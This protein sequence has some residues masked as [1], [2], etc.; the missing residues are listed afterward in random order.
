[1]RLETG[2]V[3]CGDDWPGIFIRGDDAFAL[4]QALRHVQ[5]ALPESADFYMKLSAFQVD[6]LVKLL[7]RSNTHAEGHAVDQIVHLSD[8]APSTDA[9]VRG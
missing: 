4:V 1:M 6:G 8:S 7:L 2:V 5:C 3:Q 9:K